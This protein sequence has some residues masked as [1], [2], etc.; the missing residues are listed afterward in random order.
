M[1]KKIC[2]VWVRS[3]IC[4]DKCHCVPLQDICLHNL[5][6]TMLKRDTLGYVCVPSAEAREAAADE[7]FSL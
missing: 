1:P 2:L 5:F 6:C 7:I 4:V 3:G